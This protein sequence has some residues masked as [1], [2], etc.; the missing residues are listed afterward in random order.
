MNIVLAT[1]E[2]FYLLETIRA[3]KPWF[4]I[5]L[6][7]LSM[8]TLWYHAAKWYQWYH[9]TSFSL[10][11][12]PPNYLPHHCMNIRKNYIWIA[13]V[14]YHWIRLRFL[15]NMS[16]NIWLIFNE[17]YQWCA[18][19]CKTLTKFSKR[20]PRKK[21]KHAYK[22]S[23]RYWKAHTSFYWSVQITWKMDGKFIQI[24]TGSNINSENSKILQDL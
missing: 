9:T 10:P 14:Y 19:E 7:M 8:K 24:V 18:F 22:S 2:Y 21:S 23:Y 15:F 3:K 16:H 20:W 13:W 1:N 17:S 11:H 12:Q 5:G 4:T 6:F